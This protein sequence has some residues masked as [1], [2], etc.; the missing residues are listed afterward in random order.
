MPAP[1]L[2]RHHPLH[3]CKDSFSE[4]D[5]PTVGRRDVPTGFGYQVALVSMRAMGAKPR[6]AQT[7]PASHSSWS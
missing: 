1:E 6:E 4:K 5:D 2:G 7:W 3:V